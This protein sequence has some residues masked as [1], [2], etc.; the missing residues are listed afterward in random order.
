MNIKL[1][2]PTVYMSRLF[3]ERFPE[4]CEK[5]VGILEKHG[6]A[7]AFLDKTK[8]IWCRD[9]MPIQT[10][11][12]KLVQFKYNPSYLKDKPEYTETRSDVKLICN[13]NGF[14]PEF[15]DINLDGG[16]VVKYGN[17]AIITDRI[18][19]E[20]PEYSRDELR[21]R[22]GNLLECEIIIIPAYAKSIDFTGHADGMIRFVNDNTVIGFDNSAESPSWKE[23]MERALRL[24]GLKYI[25]FPFF[26][27]ESKE[28]P[29]HA[30][31][32]YLNYIEINDLIIMPV[33]NVPGNKNEEAFNALKKLFPEKTIET[34]DYTD[35]AM[36]GGVIN[37]TTWIYFS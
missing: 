30:I 34:I 32:V 31:G 28:N 17:K 27:Y 24:A 1:K 11:T 21:K 12:Y 13:A 18:Y 33:F 37:C 5:L 4:T 26:E 20:N 8:D 14:H 6:I 19:S 16:N 29:E 23:R 7:Y 2:K 10:P 9:Y 22:L 3:E 35:V 15:S 36:L 25:N